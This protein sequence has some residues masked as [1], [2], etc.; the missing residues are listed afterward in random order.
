MAQIGKFTRETTNFIGR[1]QTFTFSQHVTI[2]PAEPSDAENA[3]DYRIH[4]GTGEDSEIGPEI[5]A[6]W[7]R[8]GERA[9]EFITLVIDDPVLPRPMRA[10]LFR[11]DDS[12]A[13]WSLNWSR[14]QKRDG[15]D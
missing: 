14:P 5:G 12:G 4:L 6:A 3:P 7:K 8:T 9:G 15:K 1:I 2:V 10:N 13:S 11:D